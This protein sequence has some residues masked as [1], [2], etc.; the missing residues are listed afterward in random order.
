MTENTTQEAECLSRL[1]AE[2]GTTSDEFVEF[3][4][5]G[6]YA[7]IKIS[8]KA[9]ILNGVKLSFEN[10]IK[11]IEPIMKSAEQHH[12]FWLQH[13]SELNWHHVI[14]TGNVFAKF[15]ELELTILHN[16]RKMEIGN[17]A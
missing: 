12:V 10:A 4:G 1:T 2:L 9:V 11:K 16:M 3:D 7:K 17:C 14:S 8:G 5:L 15:K 13:K 6:K